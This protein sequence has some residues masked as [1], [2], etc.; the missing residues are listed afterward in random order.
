MILRDST[1]TASIGQFGA[2]QTAAPAMSVEL[3]SIDL[4]NVGDFEPSITEFAQRP[5]G[6]IVALA[7]PATNIH[8]ELVISLAARL[9][10]PSIYSHRLFVRD[11]GLIAYGPDRIEQFRRAAG[12]VD[13]ILKGQKP[14]DLPVQNPTKY[15]LTINLGT[16]KALGLTV[17][18]T[19][20]ATA[21]EVIE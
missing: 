20:L 11:G 17:P 9:R 3:M 5:N 19:L 16:A 4:R 6:G 10:L 21:D 1:N 7:T 18:N 15:E 2:I 14:A 12:Y 13:R 8:R